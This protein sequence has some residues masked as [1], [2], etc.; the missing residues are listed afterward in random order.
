MPL[1]LGNLNWQLALEFCYQT[2][3]GLKRGGQAPTAMGLSEAKPI[4]EGRMTSTRFSTRCC[5]RHTAQTHK[6]RQ[7]RHKK[8]AVACAALPLISARLIAVSAPLYC[9]CADSTWSFE[10]IQ[11][12]CAPYQIIKAPRGDMVQLSSLSTRR[13][14]T[15]RPRPLRRDSMRPC[16]GALRVPGTGRRGEYLVAERAPPRRARVQVRGR[17]FPPQL[18]NNLDPALLPQ[19]EPPQRTKEGPYQTLTP[20]YLRQF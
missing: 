18:E 1:T 19:G 7:G 20:P 17:V 5:P 15:P 8:C 3:T 12:P 9:P 10:G 2:Q 16:H 14:A 4:R 13:M 6:C 11:R